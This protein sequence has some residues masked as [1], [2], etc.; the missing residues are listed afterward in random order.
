MGSDHGGA[1][2]KVQWHGGATM[3]NGV[4]AHKVV[5]SCCRATQL[6]KRKWSKPGMAPTVMFAVVIPKAS[7]YSVGS[8]NR[9]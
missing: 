4:R 1:C 7:G 8:M 2:D 3:R 5:A 6:P 9:L